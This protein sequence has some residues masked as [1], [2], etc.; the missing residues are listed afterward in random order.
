MVEVSAGGVQVVNG[1]NLRGWI[2]GE[3][4]GGSGGGCC[5]GICGGFMWS[6]GIT[7]DK[8]IFVGGG[9]ACGSGRGVGGV[10]MVVQEGEVLVLIFN[11]EVVM[12]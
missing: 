11:G 1:L 7:E 2:V 4:V 3:L 12:M 10:V 9:G 5:G 8:K 6:C